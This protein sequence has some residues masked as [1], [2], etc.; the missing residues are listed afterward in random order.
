[1]STDPRAAIAAADTALGIEFGSTRI[2]AVLIGPD[3]EVLAT[4]GHGWENHLEDGLWSYSLDKV[5]AG[6]QSAYASLVADVRERY[7][8]TPTSY[9]SIGISGMMHGYLAFDADDNLLAPFRTWRNT[10]TGRAADELT[11][12]FGFNIPLRWSIAHLHQAVI[13]AE[14][15]A[16]R[17]ARLTTLAGWV[18]EQLTGCHVLGIG[19]ASGMFPIDS[20]TGTYVESYLDQYEALVRSRVP[21]RLRD[22]LPTV[23]RAHRPDRDAPARDRDVS[24]GG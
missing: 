21:W 17:V 5:V 6:L 10:N 22:V 16:P 24:A 12:L 18:H 13:D 19:D 15:H 3:H 1:M 9:G 2:K 4:G 7:D 11:R 20:T 14:E 8:V 23:L